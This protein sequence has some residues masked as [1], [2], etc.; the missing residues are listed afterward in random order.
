MNSVGV[1]FT[2]CHSAVSSRLVNVEKKEDSNLSCTSTLGSLQEEHFFLDNRIVLEHAQRTV[3]TG[4][5]H[6]SEVASQGHRN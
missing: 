4:P 2:K 1:H 3:H 6:R 5:N